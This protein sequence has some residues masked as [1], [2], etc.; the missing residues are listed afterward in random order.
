MFLFN[1]F[2][3][4]NTSKIAKDRLKILLVSDR[5]DCSPETLDKLKDE[6]SKV[7]SKYMMIDTE[8]MEIQVTKNSYFRLET[9][10]KATLKCE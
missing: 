4:K 8:D 3:K 1:F 10:L 2:S 9:R 7:I 5:I 6:I